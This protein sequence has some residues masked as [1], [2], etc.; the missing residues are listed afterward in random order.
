[1]EP[2]SQQSRQNRKRRASTA[3]EASTQAPSQEP[4]Q[5]Q[6]KRR[7]KSTKTQSS[8]QHVEEVTYP[9]LD[10]LEE[11]A[12]ATNGEEQSSRHV[13][14][15]DAGLGHDDEEVASATTTTPHPRKLSVNRR[16]TLSPAELRDGVK[17]S[18]KLKSRKSMSALNSALSPEGQSEI[19]FIPLKDLINQRIEQRLQEKKAIIQVDGA[20]DDADLQEIDDMMVYRSHTE[21]PLFSSSRLQTSLTRTLARASATPDELAM[22]ATQ[23]LANLSDAQMDAERARFEEAIKRL[24]K[25]ASD[26]KAQYEILKIELQSLGFGGTGETWEVILAS[27]R[28]SFDSIRERLIDILDVPANLSNED[29]IDTVITRIVTLSEQVDA[30]QQ[31]IADKDQ[32]QTEL[33]REIDALVD[34]LTEAEILKTKLES[35]NKGFDEQNQEDD[36]Y[37]KDLEDKLREVEKSHVKVHA[38]YVQKETQL[39]ALRQDHED[40]DTNFNK[41]TRALEEYRQSEKKLQDIITRMEEG[42]RTALVD[43]DNEHKAVVEELNVTINQESDK[44]KIAED[45]AEDKQT[46]ITELETR[47]EQSET[48]VDKLKE[49]LANLKAS[50]EIEREAKEIAQAD[51]DTKMQTIAD[52]ETQVEQAEADLEDLRAQLEQVKELVEN[53][54]RQRE[55][56]E[57]DLDGANEKIKTL[58]TKLHNQGIQANELRGKLF[59][60]Q[61]RE[62]QSIKQLEDTAVERDEQFQADMEAEIVRREEAENLAAD[63]ANA[64]A[65]LEEQLRDLESRMI[66]NLAEKDATI[67]DLT[68]ANEEL[69]ASLEQAR[70]DL[71]TAAQDYD[72]LRVSSGSRIN[73]LEKTI[74]KLEADLS[75]HDKRIVLLERDT[76]TLAEVHATAISDRDTRIAGLHE[77]QNVLKTQII[78]LE[79]E[80]AGLERRVESEAESMLELQAVKDDEID[81]LKAAIRRKQ[82]EIDDL[83]TKA[84]GVD[85][86]WNNLMKERDATIASLE[87][88]VTET[89]ERIT[90]TRH[91]NKS[92]RD[93]FRRFVADATAKTDAM[94]AELEAVRNSAADKDRE[95][96]E[97]GMRVIAEMDRLGETVNQTVSETVV[98]KTKSA[99]KSG[100][101]QKRFHD[102]AVGMI[103]E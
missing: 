93:M 50:K 69:Q 103:E 2:D 88:A 60:I 29:L 36:Q 78:V 55:S 62:K 5:A 13:R 4:S 45:D 24:S 25:E 32:L 65:Q 22:S 84:Q 39:K 7:K 52:L 101:N 75:A 68:A 47:Y 42:H 87:T 9:K 43:L 64:I 28:R 82:A 1:M 34:R 80:K 97:E 70:A 30:Q 48:L 71:D 86:A 61:Q 83:G 89:E 46:F 98:V 18:F 26:A 44:R 66:K 94:R 40:L 6:N 72:D 53:E 21:P 79:K 95:L 96:R 15:S 35:A 73:E 10:K 16:V 77:A 56:A 12:Q 38:A 76:V 90:V 37:I 58:D 51:R 31:A 33:I 19:D 74:R 54:R 102:S 8:S 67:V 85:Q 100:K 23:T 17:P 20:E 27:I 57:A 41:L 59:E 3:S 63:R 81:D 91:E 49:Q 92:I 11:E 14:F 99:K